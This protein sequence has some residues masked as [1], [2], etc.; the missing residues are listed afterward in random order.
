MQDANGNNKELT[1]PEVVEIIQG[2]KENMALKEQNGGGGQIMMET[3]DGNKALSNSDV[4]QLIK[5]L[6]QENLQMKEHIKNYS[7]DRT[8]EEVQTFDNSNKQLIITDEDDNM[9]ILD[10]DEI[11]DYL[12]KKIDL[13][14]SLRSN[15]EPQVV[16]V[17]EPVTEPIVES[18]LNNNNIDLIQLVKNLDNK[19]DLLTQVRHK[20]TN[21]YDKKGLFKE[22]DGKQ[23]KMNYDEINDII[24][25]QQKIIEYAKEELQKTILF[26]DK[27]GGLNELTQEHLI[28]LLL[29]QMVIMIVI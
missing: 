19:L 11:S 9:E 22:V 23:V 8:I 21:P 25:E 15:I 7:S 2:Y 10:F 26:K 12:N 17:A 3:P 14:K 24:T 1:T 27:D 29:K 4:A 18:V 6:Q 28:I 5:A 13:I 16:P 20:S